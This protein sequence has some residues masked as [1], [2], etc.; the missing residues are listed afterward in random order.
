MSEIPYVLDAIINND[1]TLLRLIQKLNVIE[2][3]NTKTIEEFLSRTGT[4][5]VIS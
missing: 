3:A 2:T 1:A 5:D 4:E